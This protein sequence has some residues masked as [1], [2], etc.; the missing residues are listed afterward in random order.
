MLPLA[1]GM[2]VCLIVKKD[3]GFEVSP[4][5]VQP[6]VGGSDDQM[7]PIPVLS[8]WDLLSM[9]VEPDTRTSL[10]TLSDILVSYSTFPGM[11][12]LSL[13]LN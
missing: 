7:D 10:P 6:A 2:S 11:L 8:S 4:D 13:N 5:G 3:T 12:G 1:H 9:S